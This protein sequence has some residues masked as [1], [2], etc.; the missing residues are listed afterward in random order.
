ME[1]GYINKND[2][3]VI[4]SFDKKNYKTICYQAQRCYDDLY[5]ALKNGNDC[6]WMWEFN[7]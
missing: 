7:E 6:S 4:K 2:Y 3:T 5:K 1:D